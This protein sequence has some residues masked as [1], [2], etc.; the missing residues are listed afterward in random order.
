MV[1]SPEPHEVSRQSWGS[2]VVKQLFKI[3]IMFLMVV[4][5]LIIYALSSNL[6]NPI[7]LLTNADSVL[8]ILSITLY[9]LVLA[10]FA[11][12]VYLDHPLAFNITKNKDW[13]VFWNIF[14]TFLFIT[15]VYILLDA[16]LPKNTVYLLTGPI[17][18]LNS[19]NEVLALEIPGF[20]GENFIFYF[21]ARNAIFSIFYLLLFV[22]PLILFFIILTR[23]GRKRFVKINVDVNQ[24]TSLITKTSLFLGIPPV[25]IILF[26]I[27]IDNTTIRII[28][29][30]ILFFYLIVLPW[31]LYT[32]SKLVYVGI[33]ITAYFS[34]VNL[35]WILPL[36]GFFY[37]LPT[38]FWTILDILDFITLWNGQI[39]LLFNHS[40]DRLIF[41]ATNLERILQAVFIIVIC[42]A[43]IIIGLAEGFSILAIYRA[44][45]TGWSF[46]RTGVLASQSPPV[47]AVITS[48]ILI[49]AGW[50]AL[51]TNGLVHLIMVFRE[52]FN[53]TL[54]EITIPN[55]LMIFTFIYNYIKDLVPE[56]L[57]ITLLLIPLI[58]IISSLFKFLSISIITPRLKDAQ[59]FFLLI[60]TAYI[61]II[62]TILGDIQ[63]LAR[64]SENIDPSTVPLF[65]TQNFLSQTL[66]LFQTVEIIF[67]YIGFLIALYVIAKGIINWINEWQKRKKRTITI[68]VGNVDQIEEE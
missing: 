42:S 34:Y 3:S 2:F 56:F 63:E 60:T 35:M 23:S 55:F 68:K 10:S 8:A 16:A 11:K 17:S 25:S 48:R 5:F 19:L 38:T 58:F 24:E 22:F 1:Y 51:A 21:S 47:I 6:E 59:I 14:I 66:I 53:I 33:R 39:D 67:F 7:K 54:P 57:P 12:F 13:K 36:I 44:I 49:L 29:L 62:T 15:T 4:I 30:F 52:Y 26:L 65:E 32:C 28:Q 46:T 45:K 18:F 50:I 40:I 61:L 41:N 64:F 27:L 9:L 37:I 20:T 31:W 43:T